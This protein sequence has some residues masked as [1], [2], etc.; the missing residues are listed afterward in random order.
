M[1][2][3]EEQVCPPTPPPPPAQIISEQAFGR[4]RPGV[5]DICL[6][7]TERTFWSFP[8][9]SLLNF[10]IVTVVEAKAA[11]DLPKDKTVP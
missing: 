9:E 4:V 2:T 3:T 10:L 8:R 6:H 1:H 11:V 5:Q 7:V